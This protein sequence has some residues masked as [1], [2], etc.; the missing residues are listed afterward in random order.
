[1]ENITGRQNKPRAASIF[2]GSNLAPSLIPP[3]R[4]EGGIDLREALA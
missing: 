2:C 1:M 3:I 4:L